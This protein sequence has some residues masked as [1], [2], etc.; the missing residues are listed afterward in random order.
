M[1]VEV[2]T[3][4]TLKT[5]PGKKSEPR[6]RPETYGSLHPLNKIGEITIKS[7]GKKHPLYDRVFVMDSKE[8][9]KAPKNRYRKLAQGKRHKDC[10]CNKKAYRNERQAHEETPYDWT[11]YPCPDVAGIYHAS[12]PRKNP[13][14]PEYLKE[15]NEELEDD[16]QEFTPELVPVPEMVELGYDVETHPYMHKTEYIDCLLYTSPSPRD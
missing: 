10:G 2:Q 6:L 12:S 3:T 8:N 1:S 11:V 5:F 13:I 16:Y 7:S 9:K 4:L 14:D 15:L